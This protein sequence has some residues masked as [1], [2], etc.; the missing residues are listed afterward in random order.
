MQGGVRLNDQ[1]V[2]ESNFFIVSDHL[3]DGAAKV[4]VG[5]KRHFLVRPPEDET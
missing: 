1:P 2:T 5:K 3:Q 4:S